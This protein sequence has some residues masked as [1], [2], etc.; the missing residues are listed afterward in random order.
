MPLPLQKLFF[1]EILKTPDLQ[2]AVLASVEAFKVQEAENLEKEPVL[3][4]LE[5]FKLQLL[6]EGLTDN[7]ETKALPLQV[8]MVVETA[9][10][11]QKDFYR[12]FF[13]L[14]LD[15]GTLFQDAVVQTLTIWRKDLQSSLKADA[16]AANSNKMKKAKKH[17][18][19][20]LDG[21]K[22]R[23]DTRV[24]DLKFIEQ[25]I[26][27]CQSSEHV[28]T[29]EKLPQGLSTRT[30]DFDGYLRQISNGKTASSFTHIHVVKGLSEALS[31]FLNYL[32]FR[33]YPKLTGLCQL[34]EDAESILLANN[35][36]YKS[37]VEQIHRVETCL[38][39]GKFEK[40]HQVSI[41]VFLK[42]QKEKFYDALAKEIVEA[43]NLQDL[44]ER[45]E[46]SL[47]DDFFANELQE[48][49][50]LSECL[51]FADQIVRHAE[52]GLENLEEHS[53]EEEQFEPVTLESF[54]DPDNCWA[55]RYELI[56]L[57][58]DDL[59]KDML[60]FIDNAIVNRCFQRVQ[61]AIDRAVTKKD[62]PNIDIMHSEDLGV[63]HIFKKINAF[64]NRDWQKYK[65]SE[66]L[67]EALQTKLDTIAERYQDWENYCKLTRQSPD[68]HNENKPLYLDE[69]LSEP[70]RHSNETDPKELIED[71][72]VLIQ[73]TLREKQRQERLGEMDIYSLATKEELSL[74]DLFADDNFGDES[75]VPTA[76]T[77]LP[78]SQQ[79]ATRVNPDLADTPK[80]QPKRRRKGEVMGSDVAKQSVQCGLEC[81][82][83]LLETSQKPKADNL[84][85]EDAMDQEDG[86]RPLSKVYGI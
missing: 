49:K 29:F 10:S 14:L 70:Y 86:K 77:Y 74:S 44:V 45:L 32:R 47:L 79:A 37:L 34:T 40:T 66:D 4:A 26:Q 56:N 81:N 12:S 24:T 69:V 48:Y 28:L 16:Q 1:E 54:Y 82:E 39:Q 60:E 21:H 58:P 50:T 17:E 53:D 19:Q 51:G 52:D 76:P 2:R 23:K 5:E 6:T 84:V 41:K 22:S 36:S 31:S 72:T 33:Y 57:A 43:K 25:H 83:V 13:N 85:G 61:N 71:T 9:R 78:S 55:L 62:Y 80:K 46:C 7:I 38:I 75:L 27:H 67:C 42:E 68:S 65:N 59:P 63:K 15:R 8:K 18:A 11:W 73:E 35:F 20:K 30:T 64:A 3:S